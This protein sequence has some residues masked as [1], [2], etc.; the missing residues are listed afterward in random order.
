MNLFETITH[1]E[2]KYPTAQKEMIL[3]II[4]QLCPKF[5]DYIL[6]SLLEL[7]LDLPS[8]YF[9]TA[10][11]KQ[12]DINADIKKIGSIYYVKLSK[13]IVSKINEGYICMKIKKSEAE[14]FDF[15]YSVTP[16]TILGFYK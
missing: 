11:R 8:F 6:A 3:E 12:T 2:A 5:D 13:D 14:G 1:I 15:V 10:Y 4:E 9:S 7:K 16:K